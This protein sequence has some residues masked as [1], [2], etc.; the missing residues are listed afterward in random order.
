MQLFY[1]NAAMTSPEFVALSTKLISDM[2]VWIQEA[3]KDETMTPADLVL[4][5]ETLKIVE[6]VTYLEMEIKPD[7]AD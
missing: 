3:S 7:V 2:K 5:Q 6:R 1:R 4:L